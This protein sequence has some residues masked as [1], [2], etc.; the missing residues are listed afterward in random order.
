MSLPPT[1]RKLRHETKMVKPKTK[2]E[3]IQ[4]ISKADVLD[5][6]V[7]TIERKLL[8]TPTEIRR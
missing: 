1:N 6:V 5:L 4:A 8:L 3:L 7:E 2:Q